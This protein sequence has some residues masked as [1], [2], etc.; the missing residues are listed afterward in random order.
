MRSITQKHQK[1]RGWVNGDPF[2]IH[3]PF[4]GSDLAGGS[5]QEIEKMTMK[6]SCH[7]DELARRNLWFIITDF[8]SANR[9]IRN[10][11]EN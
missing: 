3:C 2:E 5:W 8:S 6:F 9:R 7:F 4:F 1:A 11:N 10:D